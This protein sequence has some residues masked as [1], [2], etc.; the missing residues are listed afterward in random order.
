MKKKYSIVNDQRAHTLSRQ[1][2]F[3]LIILLTPHAIDISLN[4]SRVCFFVLKFFYLAIDRCCVLFYQIFLRIT[5][6]P[7]CVGHQR[8][9]D[10]NH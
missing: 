1:I 8:N 3:S 10:F 4:S 2:S 6:M 9:Y 5:M 7:F